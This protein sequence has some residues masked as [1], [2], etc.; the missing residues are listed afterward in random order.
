MHPPQTTHLVR[1]QGRNEALAEGEETASS[2][3]HPRGGLGFFRNSVVGFLLSISDVMGMV[4][5][6]LYSI[7]VLIRKRELML[8]EASVKKL[9]LVYYYIRIRHHLLEIVINKSKLST[10]WIIHSGIIKRIM[11]RDAKWSVVAIMRLLL[12]SLLRW[13]PNPRRYPP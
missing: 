8:P 4:P 9:S 10:V 13:F 5:D 1:L 12:K 7:F 11:V 6:N 3:R 2:G